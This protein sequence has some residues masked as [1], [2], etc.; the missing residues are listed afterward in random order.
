MTRKNIEIILPEVSQDTIK[1]DLRKMKEK[2]L[3]VQ[4]GESVNT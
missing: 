3:I 1:Y 4:S 2:G